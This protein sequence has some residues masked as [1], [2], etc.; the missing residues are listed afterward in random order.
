MIAGF[1]S[2]LIPSGEYGVAAA[3]LVKPGGRL[4][5]TTCSI[6]EEENRWIVEDFLARQ[7]QFALR[8]AG[9]VLE[10]GGIELDMGEYLELWPHRHGTDAMYLAVLRPRLR[11][12]G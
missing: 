1:S 5:Y 11:P 7:A 2:S 10:K 3:R 4:V 9:E 8:P 12:A 6:L